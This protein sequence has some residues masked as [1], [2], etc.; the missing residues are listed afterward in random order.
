MQLFAK[1]DGKV[2]SDLQGLRNLEACVRILPVI[3]L[4]AESGANY[5]SFKYFKLFN[6]SVFLSENEAENNHTNFI[7]FS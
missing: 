2:R 1:E 7:G 6:F 3:F 5:L 4:A